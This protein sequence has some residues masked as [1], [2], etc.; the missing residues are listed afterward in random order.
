MLLA[1]TGMRA[2][3]A[4]ALRYKDF[5]F[6]DDNKNNNRQAFVR[7]RGEFTKTR[8]DRY[9]FLTRELVEQCKAWIDFK[10]RPRRITK[11]V[12]NSNLSLYKIKFDCTLCVTYPLI[13]N[14]I[15]KV[16]RNAAA[17]DWQMKP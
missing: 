13:K 11:V 16:N 1:A 8:T 15:F 17:S 12:S 9:V 7:I 5:D 4:L 10:Y 14:L 3:E 6:D 2:T